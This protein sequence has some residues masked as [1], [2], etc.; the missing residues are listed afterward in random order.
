MGVWLW[1]VIDD[2]ASAR[3]VARLA[4]VYA[5]IICTLS[6]FAGLLMTASAK[7]SNGSVFALPIF[8]AICAW[9]IWNGSRAW[10]IAAFVV[11][12]PM[13]I[14][15]ITSL[16]LL[17][18]IVLPFAFMGLVHGVRATSALRRFADERLMA[19]LRTR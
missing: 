2:E 7:D 14:L 11:Y 3:E 10:A 12:L 9:R 6:L 5:V 16:S 19:E 8:W 15:T 18:C 4:A 13:A 17:W 1:P